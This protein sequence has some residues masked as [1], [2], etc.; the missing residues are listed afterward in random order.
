MDRIRL[1]IADDEAEF[2]N[3]LESYFGARPDF[4]VVGAAQNGTEALSGAKLLKPDILLCDINM[5]G[6]DG[7]AVTSELTRDL[8]ECLVIILSGNDYDTFS[9][10]AM[11]A[12]AKD[13]V[14]KPVELEAI[15]AKLQDTMA[16]ANAV[17][18]KAIARKKDADKA[19]KMFAFYSPKGSAGSTSLAVNAALELARARQRVLLIDLNLQF[20]DVEFLLDLKSRACIS[21]LLGESG[22]LLTY[23]VGS[24]A[25]DHKSGLRVL[26]QNKLEESELVT[27][28]NIGAL[29]KHVRS[30]ADYDFVIL[31]LARQLDERTLS[32]IDAADTL[33]LVVTEDYLAVKNA[34]LCMS[35]FKKLGYTENKLKVLVNKASS[36]IGAHVSTHLGP[37]FATFPLQTK[38][39]EQSVKSGFPPIIEHPSNPFSKAVASLVSQSM[40]LR[41]DVPT[42]SAPEDSSISGMF[43]KLFS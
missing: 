17:K 7:L 8:P 33:F 28:A 9:K 32:A 27:A 12:G 6:M 21:G 31:D 43:K 39:F 19:A 20:G 40:L 3:L 30:S 1:M 35:L 5:P 23:K 41:K 16:T 38:L 24:A 29:L 13:Y 37:P 42:A 18:T 2:R 25:E 26:Y 36:Q 22:E 4:E 10:K 15:A 14:S 34:K 11:L